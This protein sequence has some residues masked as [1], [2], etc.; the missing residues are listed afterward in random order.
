LGHADLAI[1]ERQ[2]TVG[3]PECD[4]GARVKSGRSLVIPTSAE[5][6][7]SYVDYLNAEYGTLDP[8]SYRRS[9]TWW[10]GFGGERES[11]SG[12][13]C[14][15]YLQD[16]TVAQ[17]RRDGEREGVARPRLDH[18]GDRYVWLT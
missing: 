12:R 7:R 15:V 1:A 14:C 18:Y 9:T 17:K 13:T 6:M 11:R 16:L 10:A 2:L 4:N 5:L 3:P 8:L